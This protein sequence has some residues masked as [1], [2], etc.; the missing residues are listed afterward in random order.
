MNKEAAG[1]DL[2]PDAADRLRDQG[3]GG[4]VRLGPLPPRGLGRRQH[5]LRRAERRQRH[6]HRRPAPAAAVQGL[7]ELRQ[8]CRRRDLDE[9]RP[10]QHRLQRSGGLRRREQPLRGPGRRHLPLRRDAAL[11]DQRQRH[12]PHARAARSERHDRNPGLLRRESPPPTS[13]SPPPSG[14]RR[15]SRSPRAI[16]SSCRGIS[17]SRTATSPPT[18]RPSGAAKSGS[19]SDTFRVPLSAR[20]PFNPDATRSPSV[21]PISTVKRSP[22]VAENGARQA[23]SRFM[24]TS[25]AV[26]RQAVSLN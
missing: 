9:D 10:Q 1:D 12:G 18:T 16:P 7:D 6:R 25:V 22:R 15:W 4:A 11:Q 20:L 19:R 3:A 21:R 17:G 8:L 5:L 14:C 13:R 23:K 2:G 26:E 24:A